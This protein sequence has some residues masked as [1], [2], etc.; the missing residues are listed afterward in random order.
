MLLHM[1]LHDLVH[2]LLI[3]LMLLR[4]LYQLDPAP[5]PHCLH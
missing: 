1:F 2:H 5:S 4:N 3:G